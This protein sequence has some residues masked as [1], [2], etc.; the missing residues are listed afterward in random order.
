[1]YFYSLIQGSITTFLNNEGLG[2]C[3]A[4]IIILHSIQYIKTIKP[5]QR[6]LFFLTLWLFVFSTRLL[7][8]NIHVVAF[9]IVGAGYWYHSLLQARNIKIAILRGYLFGLGYYGAGNYWIANMTAVDNWYVASGIFILYSACLATVQ[10]INAGVFYQMRLQNIL[11]KNDNALHFYHIILLSII[12]YIS[13][14][15]FLHGLYNYPWQII[16]YNFGYDLITRQLFCTFGV[17]GMSVLLV[18]LA[19]CFG[20]WLFT[21]QKQY[22]ITVFAIYISCAIWGYGR[23]QYYNNTALQTMEIVAGLV[24]LTSPDVRHPDDYELLQSTIDEVSQS[25]P[26]IIILPETTI[27]AHRDQSPFL[28]EIIDQISEATLLIIGGFS[29]TA[30]NDYDIINKHK[31]RQSVLWVIKDREII[32]KHVK[33]KLIPILEAYPGMIKSLM[34]TLAPRVAK[35]RLLQGSGDDYLCE[36]YQ[37]YHASLVICYESIYPESIAP[38]SQLAIVLSNDAFFSPKENQQ[39][40]VINKV[41]AAEYGIPIIRNACH[42]FSG[43]IDGLGRIT[44]AI[45]DIHYVDHVIFHIPK[46]LPVTLFAILHEYVASILLTTLSF[47]ALWPLL[48]LRYKRRKNN[49]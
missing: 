43:V 28:T 34:M 31:D 39:I 46:R 10:A 20:T 48:L 49:V 17:Y 42:G 29:D 24:H 33:H 18:I 11:F 3:I 27:R 41:R 16:G 25:Y 6:I 2:F 36:L 21:K 5:Q 35:L 14:L 47:M 38:Y 32:H 44:V 8:R 37:D 23:T 9:T 19:S 30:E 7:A 4:S 22:I 26:D 40:L 1:M 45:P 13:E 15:L 12:W